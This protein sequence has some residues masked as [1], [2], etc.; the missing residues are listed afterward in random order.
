MDNPNLIY[1]IPETEIT[2]LASFFDAVKTRI[3]EDEKKVNHTILLRGLERGICIEL[4]HPDFDEKPN[5]TLTVHISYE[6]VE[7]RFY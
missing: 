5:N 4:V 7:P 1:H 3:V 2:D 6:G